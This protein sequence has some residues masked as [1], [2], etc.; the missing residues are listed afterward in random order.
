[1]ANVL[2]GYGYD[3]ISTDL[4]DRGFED[5]LGEFNFLD[6]LRPHQ[7]CDAIITNPPFNL[8]SKFISKALSFTPIV[9]M[10]LKSQFWHAARRLP[11]FEKHPPSRVLPLTWRLDFT[12]G[13]APT[14]DCTWFVWGVEGIPFKPLS[15]PGPDLKLL[16]AQAALPEWLQ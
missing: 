14:M 7:P 10:L 16:C 13:G 12:G 15:K 5:M 3:V 9:A 1:M 11:L 2:E 4:V 6:V 8:A